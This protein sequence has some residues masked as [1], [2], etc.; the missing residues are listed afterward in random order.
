MWGG[1][2]SL[3]Y[4]VQGIASTAVTCA[5]AWAWRSALN[6]DLKAAI[7]IVATLLA[8]PHVLDYD[9]VVLAIAIAFFARHGLSRGFRDY[10]ASVL[11][12]AWIVPLLSRGLAGVTGI[13]LGLLAL[14]AL[15][16]LTLRRALL[17][18]AVLA[19]G[20]RRTAHA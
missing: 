10:E 12:A 20:A 9:L 14:L 13:P 15:Y 19:S 5:T 7:L 8:S 3:A 6:Y 17:D 18:R 16:V 2:V 4:A 1:T 11:A